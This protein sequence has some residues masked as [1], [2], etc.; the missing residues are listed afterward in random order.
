MYYISQY[1]LEMRWRFLYITLAFI[2]SFLVCYIYKY[3]FFYIFCKPFLIFNSKFLF[4]ELTEGFYTMI[5]ITTISSLCVTFPFILYQLWAFSVPSIYQFQRLQYN[6]IFFLFFILLFIEFYFI[7]SFLFPKI[8][9][10]LMGFQIKLFESHNLPSIEFTPR[11]ISYVSYTTAFFVFFFLLFQLPVLALMIFSKN[12]ISC[13]T[14]C[15]Q[16]KMV[17]FL[18]IF[19][20]ALLSPPEFL[21]QLIL[22][23]SFYTIYEFIVFLGFFYEPKLQ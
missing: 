6:K 13:F 21:S 15:K 10:F 23:F 9:G 3:E 7:Y 11:I 22:S 16:R 5:H 18:C 12:L 8:C 1:F 17:V 4:F 19:F 14:L 2:W 20:S